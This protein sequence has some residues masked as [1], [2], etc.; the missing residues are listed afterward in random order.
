MVRIRPGSMEITIM[1]KINL[2]N[3]ESLDFG[4]KA[5][6]LHKEDPEKVIEEF[7]TYFFD[8]LREILADNNDFTSE[9]SGDDLQ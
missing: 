1:R 8:K 9:Y 5:S 7:S 4:L 3:Y 6:L 2:G